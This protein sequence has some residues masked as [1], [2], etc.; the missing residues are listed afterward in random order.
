MI[1]KS[2][3][4]A[5][6]LAGGIGATNSAMAAS[7]DECANWLCLPAGFP[8]GS[9]CEGPYDAMMDRLKEGKSP[10]PNYSSCAS[11]ESYDPQ[12][13]M[14]QKYGNATFYNGEYHKN[15]TCRMYGNN[16]YRPHG[17]MGR[18]YWYFELYQ[19]DGSVVPMEQGNAG[20][21]RVVDNTRYIPK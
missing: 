5:I 4:L 12:F 10:L 17:C 2:L 16:E 13:A 15:E 6:A 8:G 3:I 18:N 20:Y 1:H 11:K 21:G 14:S 9:N 19:A 7:D